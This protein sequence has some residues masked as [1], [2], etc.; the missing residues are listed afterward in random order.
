MTIFK[1]KFNTE[2]FFEKEWRKEN[3]SIIFANLMMQSKINKNI[4]AKKFCYLVFPKNYEFK[5]NKKAK[6]MM[7]IYKQKACLLTDVEDSIENLIKE[8]NDILKIE[9][10]KDKYILTINNKNKILIIAII[11]SKI[12]KCLQK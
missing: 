11:T 8:F 2:L 1:Y 12:E 9:K 6:A 4:V 7:I 3:I 10:Q 5:E